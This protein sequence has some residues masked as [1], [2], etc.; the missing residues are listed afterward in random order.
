METSYQ[1]EK[2][3]LNIRPVKFVLWLFIVSS[4]MLFAA[5]TSAYIVR[6]GEGNWTLF[7][8]PKAFIYNSVVILAS[9][10]TMHWAYLS[11]KR[12]AFN[13][14]KIGLWLT[15]LLGLVFLAGQFYSWQVLVKE[16]VFFTGNPS[17]SF[18]Y[19]ISGF[20]GLHIIAGL[21]MILNSL[22]G[23]YRNIPQ[24]R[25]IFRLEMTA[26]FWHFLDI[27]WIYLY[28]FLLLNQ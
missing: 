20:H 15:F 28:V 4:I 23:V 1:Q 22:L 12:L 8:L 6:K 24:V 11:A 18:L 16:G 17:G 19:V 14:Q 2:D 3:K 10:L 5:W 25:N 7:L 13:K 27:L 21:L 26:I 9:S